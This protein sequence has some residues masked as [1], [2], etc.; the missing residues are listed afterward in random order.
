MIDLSDLVDLID[1]DIFEG[2]GDGIYL[3]LEIA[4]R[5]V[6]ELR[7]KDNTV[8]FYKEKQDLLNKKEELIVKPLQARI[9]S[10]E[11][12]AAIDNKNFESTTRLLN[13]TID[14]K[15]R[16]IEE[17]RETIRRYENVYG[18]VPPAVTEL[19]MMKRPIQRISMMKVLEDFSYRIQIVFND[20]GSE[21]TDFT[22]AVKPSHVLED[23]VKKYGTQVYKFKSFITQIEMI[24]TPKP[25]ST[26][27]L[28]DELFK[29]FDK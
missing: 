19:G 23:L 5:V 21:Y 8:I 2:D 3:P 1:Q 18:D 16:T 28:Y 13:M 14:T 9:A 25:K 12:K 27:D 7:N 24:D 10:L 26:R 17:L 6:E 22:H 29:D 4:E 11:R 15:N 20:G